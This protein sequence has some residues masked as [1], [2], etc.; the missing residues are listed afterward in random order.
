MAEL[1]V[2]QQNSSV[3]WCSFPST[4]SGGNPEPK[5]NMWVHLLEALNPYCHEE[6]L[7]LCQESESEWVAW[8][9]DHG[10]AMLHIHQFCI[11]P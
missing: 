7:L 5:E 6:A 11:N 4:W 2:T 1:D 3:N 9:P 10:E 8:I